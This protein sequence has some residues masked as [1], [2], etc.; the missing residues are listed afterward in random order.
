MWPYIGL[1]GLLFAL[2]ISAPRAWTGKPRRL[3]R[4]APLAARRFVPL[5]AASLRTEAPTLA[6]ETAPP[7][8]LPTLAPRRR[9]PAGPA[10]PRSLVAPECG[11]PSLQAS[12]DAT[13]PAESVFQLLAPRIASA[14]LMLD[15]LAMA[16]AE[17]PSDERSGL[18]R[19]ALAPANTAESLDVALPALPPVETPLAAPAVSADWLAPTALLEQLRDLVGECE[20]GAWAM[21]TIDA[22]RAFSAV[23]PR[24]LDAAAPA[25][26]EV[27]RRRYEGDALAESAARPE[28]AT[29][30]RRVCDALERRLKVWDAA[31]DRLQSLRENTLR[32][33]DAADLAPAL[34][35]AELRLASREDAQVWRE[36]LLLDELRAMNASRA[37]LAEDARSSLGAQVFDRFTSPTLSTADRKLL[38]NRDLQRLAEALRG[39]SNSEEELFALARSVERFESG[40][41][42]SDAQ[43]LAAEARRLALSSVESDRELSWTLN[44]RFRNANIRLEFTADLISRLLPEGTPREQDVAETILGV[45]NRGRSLTTTR[46][47]FRT[48][49][50]RRRLHLELLAHGDID[51]WTTATSGPARFQNEGRANFSAWRRLRLDRRGWHAEPV[52]IEVA[53]TTSLRGVR[54]DFDRLPLIGRLVQRVARDQYR[55]KR[56]AAQQEAERRIEHKVRAELTSETERALAAANV[57]WRQDLMTPMERLGVMPKIIEAGSNPRSAAVRIRLAGD[58]QLGAHTPRPRLPQDALL[59]L[60]VHQSAINN[61]LEGLDL[62]GRAF[63]LVDLGAWLSEKLNREDLLPADSLRDDVWIHFAEKDAVYARL[64]DDQIE[65]NIQFAEFITT[66]RSWHNF[67]VRVRYRPRADQLQ[68]DLV[69]EGPIELVGDSVRGVE[70]ALRGIVTRMFPDD[71]P[72]SLVPQRLATNPRLQGLRV[73]HF[74][75]DDGWLSVA[76]GEEQDGALSGKRDAVVTK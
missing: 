17:P 36:Y 76:I 47:F 16:A 55:A 8:S 50:D 54:T 48:R 15:T 24:D 23:D 44:Q 49:D 73:E 61:L 37:S 67:G 6:Q 20:T 38:G 72:W 33:G 1:L 58:S 34:Q 53:S 41:A 26:G 19:L 51:S 75:I 74:L 45:P 69:R 10:A 35:R 46:L 4:P 29:R 31:L 56:G 7:R 27:W 32:G 42:P 43:V 68:A 64:V 11:L 18:D 25:L 60:Q 14:P 2:S 59:S 40:L 12:S 13:F 9:A 52:Q 22:V 39:W 21:E 63:N 30:M 66:H 28:L 57:H 71:A 3:V 62:N 65:L 5:A 70:M